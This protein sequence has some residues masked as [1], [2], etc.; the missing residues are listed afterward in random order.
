MS[1][2]LHLHLDPVGGVAGDMF[3]AAL[4]DVW[5]ELADGAIAAVRAAGLDDDVQIE[6]RPHR[7]GVLVGSRFRVARN[8]AKAGEAGHRHVHW[9]DLREHLRTV[10]L[11]RPVLDRVLAIFALLAEAEAGV[12]GVEVDAATFHEVGA[13]DSIADIVASAFLIEAI[14]VERW[15]VGCLP[16]GAGRVRCAHGELPVPAPATVR[17]LQGFAFHDDGRSGERVTP[18]GAAILRQLGP[19][20]QLEP[21]AKRLLKTG[22]GFGLRTLDGMSNVLRALVFDAEPTSEMFTVGRGAESVAVLSFEIDDQTPED[23][24]IGLDHLRARDD[25]LDIVQVPVFG[26]KGRLATAIRVLVRPAAVDAVIAACFEET[27]TLGVRWRLEQRAVLARQTLTAENERSVKLAER[28]RGQVTA[29]AESDDLA[30]IAGHASRE[31]VRRSVEADALSQERAKE[32][33]EA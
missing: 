10:P 6:H 24:A 25:V 12:H 31:M 11:D 22:H 32:E 30:S 8:D 26:K 27:T 4:L 14:G 13:W 29:K 33:D 2:D 19:S 9:R 16:L 18:T 23:L 7:D 3:V 21:G 17:L 20:G 1:R 28:P 5:P 15:S